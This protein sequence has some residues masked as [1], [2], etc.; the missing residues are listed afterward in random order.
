MAGGF[1]GLP[2]ATGSAVSP[3]NVD[4]LMQILRLRQQAQ[5][6]AMERKMAQQQAA[7]QAQ[8]FQQSF[9]RRNMESDRAFGAD[10][11]AQQAQLGLTRERLGKEDAANQSRLGL[12]R[13]RFAEAR[14]AQMEQEK[15]QREADA[16]AQKAR[17][18]AMS[19]KASKEQRARTMSDVASRASAI[20]AQN[21]P[22]LKSDL[23]QRLGHEPSLEE[24]RDDMLTQTL[25]L[26][27]EDRVSAQSA[28]DQ[29][30]EMASTG[31]AKASDRALRKSANESMAESRA[32]KP[33]Q[34]ERKSLR[35]AIDDA[36]EKLID[37]DSRIAYLASTGADTGALELR[38]QIL[39]HRVQ[40][41]EKKLTD[42]EVGASKRIAQ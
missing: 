3:L 17:D 42:L 1:M 32:A 16:A 20:I 24:L 38:K 23:A 26:E 36:D 31:E 35:A 21:L 12:D 25:A 30:Y 10:Q 19:D 40:E 22:A 7:Q 27:G 41:M 29:W 34:D 4:P 37:L 11:Q 18:Q 13:E 8:Q 5:Q 39:E 6:A 33:L 9:S 28:I 14:R 15:M 2:I